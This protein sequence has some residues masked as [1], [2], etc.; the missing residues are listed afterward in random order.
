MLIVLTLWLSS[1]GGAPIAERAP[2]EDAA[3]IARRKLVAAARG[4]PAIGDVQSAAARCSDPL[5]PERGAVA[6][7]KSAALL[8][9]VTAEVRFDDRSY[10]IVGHQASGEVDYSRLAPGWTAAVR[11][12]WDLGGL[13][14]PQ[15]GRLTARGLLE[16]AQRRDQAVKGATAAFFERRRRRLAL[17]MEPPSDPAARAREELEVERLGAE[18]DAL[19]CGAFAEP[20]R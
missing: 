16:S 18:L 12:T 6:R 13:V 17:E 15:S 9:K 3:W 2:V 10:R 5:G 19:T 14:A 1:L 11:A 8:P 4:D 7:A 20:V